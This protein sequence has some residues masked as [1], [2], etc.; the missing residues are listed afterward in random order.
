MLLVT[1]IGKRNSMRSR[2]PERLQGYFFVRFKYRRVLLCNRASGSLVLQ[3]V[4][5]QQP[6]Q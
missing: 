3:P 4:A 2:S 1:W 6:K 5:V